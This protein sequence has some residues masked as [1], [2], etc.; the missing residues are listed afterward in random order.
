MLK[1]S[2][3][4]FRVPFDDFSLLY[5]ANTGN[6]QKMAGPHATAIAEILSGEPVEVPP[7]LMDSEMESVLFSGGFLVPAELE[8]A[9]TVRERFWKARAEGNMVLTLTTTQDCNLGCYYCYEDRTKDKLRSET[10]P[11]IVANTR[12]KLID[13]G[14]RSLHVDWYGGEPMLNVDFIEEA[15]LAL[16]ALCDEIGVHYSASM[17]TNGTCWPEDVASFVAKHKI[18]QVQVSFDGMRANHDKRR[19][20]RKGYKPTEDAS[21][22]DQAV[23]L[24]DRLLKCV[25]VSVR[26]NIDR[27]NLPDSIPF[28]DMARARGWFDPDNP[29]LLQPA[30][31][32]AY[33]D[34]S[35]FMRKIEL[36]R[37]EF[38]DA[39]AVMYG[40]FRGEAPIE[41][42]PDGF[43]F[44]LEHVCAALARD[45][46]VVGADGSIY[47]CGLQVGE[48]QRAV[49]KLTE[50]GVHMD[51][52][53]HD[54]WES[55]DPTL[56]ETCGNCS[57]LP[58]C[59]GGCPKKHLEGDKHGLREQCAY[60]RNNLARLVATKV[61]R[62]PQQPPY[63]V[64]EQFR[65]GV[66][67]SY[68]KEVDKA[69]PIPV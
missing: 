63:T 6:V 67:E 62:A 59:L 44:P 12:Q 23:A 40:A 58:V 26:F 42:V 16:Q 52:R 39:Q 20:Y 24:V 2:R 32:S 47:R 69:W 25:T 9:L 65:D 27:G 49:G 57:F 1:S 18:R 55:F 51:G 61:D 50:E 60:W 45:S 41:E 38:D 54:W 4:N 3:Y 28:V 31:L 21:S 7:G 30:R 34:R 11:E 37:E 36:S 64:E 13:G 43:P 8:E 14:K 56:Q 48:T 19:H 5:N 68:L 29:V 10:V 33:T 53:D 66:P 15:S 46:S 17:I 35:G 22:F